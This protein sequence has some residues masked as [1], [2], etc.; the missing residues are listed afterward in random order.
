VQSG[1][2]LFDRDLDPHPRRSLDPE[3]ISIAPYQR[4]IVNPFLSVLLLVII[5]AI[6]QKAIQTE[7]FGIFPL[8]VILILIDVFLVQYH[9]LD[10]GATGWLLRYRKHGCPTVVTRFQRGELRRFRGPS[11]R[12]QLA[13]WIVFLLVALVL[14][15]IVLFSW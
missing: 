12:L 6:A 1:P 11:V 10:C 15:L 9:C 7:T 5:I 2:D 13:M 4:L 8:L 3:H 14:G